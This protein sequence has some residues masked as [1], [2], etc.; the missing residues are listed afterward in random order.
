MNASVS[1]EE[2]RNV[3]RFARA[4]RAG[5]LAS[6]DSRHDGAPANALV[7]YACD[8]D[9]SPI[10]LF[11]TLSEHTRN[12]RDDPRAA[13]L[14]EAA[15]SHRNPQA[16]PRVSFV[17]T[18]KKATAKQVDHLRDRFLACHP[19]A[20]LYAGFGD[21]AFYRMIVERVH[22]VGGFAQARWLPAKRV[23]IKDRA[24]LASIS[25]TA[26]G[27]IEHMNNDHADALDLCARKILRRRGAGWQMTGL[28]P[29][30]CD[31][32]RG[33][34]VARLNFETT[35]ESADDCRRELVALTKK[36]R[37]MG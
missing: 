24:I 13:L 5:A 29:D 22:A 14:I 18:V 27:V 35:V 10:F 12:L 30:G 11:S 8:L 15:K 20:K 16:G 36:A 19:D 2:G 25:D 28:D 37:Q 3:R 21:F 34:Y 7:T 26:A 33:P 31:L 23:I 17:G 32:R 4:H 6:V 1:S 9:G